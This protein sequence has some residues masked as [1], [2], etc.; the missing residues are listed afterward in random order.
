MNTYIGLLIGSLFISVL[1]IEMQPSKPR[2]T[3][4]QLQLEL[5]FRNC[6]SVNECSTISR[7]LERVE[8]NRK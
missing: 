2:K 6:K 5:M 7:V 4:Y 3:E 1:H 8:R